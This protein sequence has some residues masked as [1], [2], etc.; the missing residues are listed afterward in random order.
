MFGL[1]F[2]D[3]GR[4]EPITAAMSPDS[5]RSLSDILSV[6][7]SSFTGRTSGIVL[8]APCGLVSFMPPSTQVTPDRSTP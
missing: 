5:S 1:V 4:P 3:F 8:G 6:C 2:T 7:S